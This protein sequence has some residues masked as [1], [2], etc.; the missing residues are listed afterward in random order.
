MYGR[1]EQSDTGIH[2]TTMHVD[3]DMFTR[4]LIQR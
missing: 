1:F 3:I 4:H 2:Y